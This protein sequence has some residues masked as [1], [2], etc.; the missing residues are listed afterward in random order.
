MRLMQLMPWLICVLKLISKVQMFVLK[1]DK[2]LIISNKTQT[3]YTVEDVDAMVHEI[4]TLRKRLFEISYIEGNDKAT[5][6][7]TGLPSWF[8][9]LHLY[10]FLSTD[11]LSSVGLSCEEELL[12]VLCHL[13]LGLSIQDLAKRL[14]VSVAN[15]SM[16]FQMWLNYKIEL[17]DYLA[18]K[19]SFAAEYATSYPAEISKLLSKHWLFR[20]LLKHHQILVSF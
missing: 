10:M 5:S 3:E 4:Y 9:F 19:R 16:I 6:Y 20:Y 7:Y 2:W 17:P 13:R 1:P 18:T 11:V 8:V 12:A 14:N 15:M